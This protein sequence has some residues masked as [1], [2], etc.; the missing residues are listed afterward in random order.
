MENNSLKAIVFVSSSL[1][2]REVRDG[3]SRVRNGMPRTCPQV[4]LH[5]LYLECNYI[6]HSWGCVGIKLKLHGLKPL[7][8]GNFKYKLFV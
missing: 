6:E 8:L 4:Y 7:K 2:V 5:L 3:A 1:I